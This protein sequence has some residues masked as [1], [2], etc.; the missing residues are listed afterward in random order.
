MTEKFINTHSQAKPIGKTDLAIEITQ[1]DTDNQAFVFRVRQP[2]NGEIVL[3]SEQ[4]K[5]RKEAVKG[6]AAVL[7]NGGV[8]DSYRV[9]PTKD[10][11]YSITIQGG[12][13]AVFRTSE[14]YA[15]ADAARAGV[16][17]KVRKILRAILD[18]DASPSQSEQSDATNPKAQPSGATLQPVQ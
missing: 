18:A 17:T 12:D 4:Y 5:G 1:D 8:K 9:E 7:Q 6:L 10:N 11:A 16:Q 14:P 2:R 13:R 3:R 15:S